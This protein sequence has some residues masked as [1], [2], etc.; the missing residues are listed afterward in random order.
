MRDVEL[1]G[2]ILQR[3]YDYR[4]RG[5]LQ[6]TD[7]VAAVRGTEALLAASISEQL[8][9]AGL[10]EW[11]TS[12][13]MTG[14]GGIGRITAE[15]VAVIEGHRE[16]LITLSLHG[17]GVVGGARASL[18]MVGPLASANPALLDKALAAI[19]QTS[20]PLADKAAAKTLIRELGAN[21]LAW[22][23]L[24]AM[25]G[26]SFDEAARTQGAVKQAS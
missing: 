6:L 1:R 25:F 15:G 22:S 20:S 3:F 14:V 7:I 9:K 17:R 16:P 19:D 10:V 5:I 11:K 24:R 8:A 4:H 12:K 21:P 23:A 26:A 13:T 18:R 2:A